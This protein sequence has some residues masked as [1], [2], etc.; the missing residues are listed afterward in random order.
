MVGFILHL[1]SSNNAVLL[2]YFSFGVKTRFSDIFDIS[3]QMD[4]NNL[5]VLL[6]REEIFIG[7]CFEL[8]RIK[9]CI[10]N[11]TFENE[12]W[13]LLYLS[14]LSLYL[15]MHQKT[16]HNSSLTPLDKKHTTLTTVTF[17]AFC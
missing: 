12:F 15:L 10:S 16:Q 14:D 2:N 11:Q 5:V 7:N 3:N 9:D 6:I 17:I 13:Y 4:F 8:N 1:N